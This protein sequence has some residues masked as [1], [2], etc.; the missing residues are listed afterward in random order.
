MTVINLSDVP[1]TSISDRDLAALAEWANKQKHLAF[2]EPQIAK[3]FAMIR[4]GADTILRAR[5]LRSSKEKP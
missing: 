4:E 3:S 1:E 2:R 5:A